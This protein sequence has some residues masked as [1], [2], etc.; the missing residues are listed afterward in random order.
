MLHVILPWIITSPSCSNS[1]AVLAPLDLLIGLGTVYA[2]GFLLWIRT[3][4]SNS[5][6]T[7]SSHGDASD[8]QRA[9]RHRSAEDLRYITFLWMAFGATGLLS[10]DV[11][12]ASR[13][14]SS[15]SKGNASIL[16]IIW[17]ASST[18]VV[19][20]AFVSLS[21]LLSIGADAEIEA[22]AGVLRRVNKI[23]TKAIKL[24]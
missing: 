12:W 20:L 5:Y 10:N 17:I 14:V 6:F 24:Q 13:I 22:A 16:W 4:T 11:I 21:H 2:F 9:S 19:A 23:T 8:Q 3:T 15:A 18:T 7:F 1:I